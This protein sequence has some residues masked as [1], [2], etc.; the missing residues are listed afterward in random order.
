MYFQDLILTLLQYWGSKGCLILEPYDIE[1][2]AGTMNPHTFLRALGPEPWKV[3]YV[4]PSRRPA[5][6][7]YGENP[8]RVYQHHQL[9]VILKP[10]PEDVQDLYLNSLKAIGIEPLKHD[11]RF[12]EDNWEA[13][14]LGAWGL[15]WEVWLDGM[16]IT[17]FTYFQ[18][19]GSINCDLESAEL[20]YGLER[21]AMYLQDVDNIFDI[22]WCEGIKYGE[23]FKQAEYEQ[24]VYSF[25]KASIEN[26]TTL[27]NMY[28]EEA[29]KAIEGDLVIPCYD[30]VL[31]CSHV[32]NVLDARGAISVT[33]R[34][35]YISRVR[36][37]AKLVAQKHLEKREKSGYPLIKQ[38]G[39]SNE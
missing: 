5:D 15:G 12:V 24:S 25:E 18:Q 21:I 1:K 29:Q 34:T 31:K 4:E 19:I 2:G 14:T 6:A 37:L 7:R 27:F 3:V 38:G 9:Q 22:E 16:E 35:H 8:N 30:Y 10:S 17:Q 36:N 11:I 32:F 39:V 28:E 26:L 33:E 23:I 13:P 20:T